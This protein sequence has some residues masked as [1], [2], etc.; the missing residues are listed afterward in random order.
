MSMDNEAMARSPGT[1][2]YVMPVPVWLKPAVLA[3]S[4]GCPRRVE[5]VEHDG[6]PELVLLLSTRL[7]EKLSAHRQLP[8]EIGQGVGLEVPFRTEARSPLPVTKSSVGS[9]ALRSL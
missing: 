3:P 8:V 7:P 9:V 5:E 1:W 4:E 2:T 6:K